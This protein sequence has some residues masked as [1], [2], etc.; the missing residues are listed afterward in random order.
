MTD[1]AHLDASRLRAL[2]LIR[3]LKA[4]DYSASHAQL[5]M[6]L[7]GASAQDL[8]ALADDT[9]LSLPRGAS[10]MIEEVL[11]VIPEAGFARLA[12]RALDALE[13]QPSP[14]MREICDEVLQEASLQIGPALQP[15]L[16]RLFELAP[17]RGWTAENRPWRAAQEEDVA[18][19]NEKLVAGDQEARRKAFACLIETRRP[20][21]MA[22]AAEAYPTLALKYPFSLYLRGVDHDGPGQPLYGAPCAHLIFPE[23]YMYGGS[24]D[25]APGAQHPTWTLPGDGSLHRFGGAGSTACGLCAGQLHHLVTL[26]ERTMFGET[27]SGEATLSLEVCLSCLGWERDLLFYRHG[28]DGLPSPLHHGA[29]TPRFPANALAATEVRLA[30]TPARWTWQQWG[31]GNLHRVGGAPVWVQSPDYPDCPTCAR[32]MHFAMQL[33]SELP[34]TDEDESWLWGSGGICYVF[35]CQP[36]RTIGYLWQCT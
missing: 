2:D 9:L 21:A 22:I 13:Q 16:G 7:R 30:P 26:P 27:A 20:D 11:C 3:V 35:Q 23:N 10:N 28:D 36:C 19:L 14:A 29:V 25:P 18:F 4:G 15:Q 17:N 32:T 5:Q 33:D 34:T 6:F 24:A 8:D 12:A 31:S 1:N